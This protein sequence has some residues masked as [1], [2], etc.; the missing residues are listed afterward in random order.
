MLMIYTLLYGFKYSYLIQ[1]IFTLLYTI[2]Y[3]YQLFLNKNK[4]KKNKNRKAAELDDISPEVWKTRQFNLLTS[5]R[6]L[7][8]YTEGR[9]SKYYS[10]TAY[11][12]KL[13]QS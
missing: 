11:P 1:I 10:P 13:S 6:F 12:K 4:N 2:K 3:F 7:T 8:P 9:W 5:P